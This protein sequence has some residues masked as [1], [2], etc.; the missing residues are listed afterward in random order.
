M[1]LS[2]DSPDRYDRIL[3]AVGSVFDQLGTWPDHNRALEL[4]A[5]AVEK[6]IDKEIGRQDRPKG[7]DG[8]GSCGGNPMIETTVHQ[9]WPTQ[10]AENWL[11]VI[12][13][14]PPPTPTPLER[15]LD[16]LGPHLRYQ[17]LYRPTV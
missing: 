17:P 15:A 1:S 12:P 8:Y 3:Y 14:A 2:P 7:S 5:D 10:L 11:A 16:I 4:L 9:A 6:L 13:A